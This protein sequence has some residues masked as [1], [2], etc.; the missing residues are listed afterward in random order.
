MSLDLQMDEELP[1]ADLHGMTVYEAKHELDLAL[2]RASV[3]KERAVRV[4]VGRGSGRLYSEM[5]THLRGHKQVDRVVDSD[6]EFELGA[7]LYAV[8]A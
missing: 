7:V 5:K 4:I 1:E 8:I 3:Q 6:A 2:D